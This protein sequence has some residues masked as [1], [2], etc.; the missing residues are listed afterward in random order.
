MRISILKYQL[1][2]GNL[3]PFL[4]SSYSAGLGELSISCMFDVLATV[5]FHSDS[6][7]RVR[8][9][10]MARDRRKKA[11]GKSDCQTESME[12]G[13]ALPHRQGNVE[14]KGAHRAN[15]PTASSIRGLQIPKTSPFRS[16]PTAGSMCMSSRRC[17]EDFL[18]DR[19][20]CSLRFKNDARMGLYRTHGKKEGFRYGLPT[21]Y[22]LSATA[23]L[24]PRIC[25]RSQVDT[26]RSST[27]LTDSK[28]PIPIG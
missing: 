15:S 16:T 7:H 25:S 2:I 24:P 18:Q 11:P 20:D 21:R 28:S 6:E 8:E 13:E 4:W 22:C 23:A 5:A 10:K 26:S 9:S 14:S 3:N 12:R 27:F 17:G 1:N 19:E